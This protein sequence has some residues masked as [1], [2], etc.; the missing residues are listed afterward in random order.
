MLS[1]TYTIQKIGIINST[2]ENSNFQLKQKASNP[3][4]DSCMYI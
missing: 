2:L 4:E 1:R 3:L